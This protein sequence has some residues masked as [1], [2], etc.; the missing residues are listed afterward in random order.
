ML[1]VELGANALGFIF[2]PTSPR[3]LPEVPDWIDDI[4]PF[5]ARVAVFGLA[6]VSFL[7]T[8][9]HAVQGLSESFGMRGHDLD[10]RP[11]ERLQRIAV[12]RCRQEDRPESLVA[13]LPD[14]DAILLDAY[15]EGQY[16]GTGLRLDWDLASEIVRLAPLPVILAGGLTPDNIAEAIAKV[17][18]YAVD[19]ASGVESSPGVKDP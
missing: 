19:V 12:L 15:A 17:K 1:A 14:A 6:P 18:P 4:P 3:F 13:N 9:F 11:K 2:E 10:V 16:G 8:S 7:D 5:V